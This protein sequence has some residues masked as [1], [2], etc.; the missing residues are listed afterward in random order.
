MA[1]SPRMLCSSTVHH[2]PTPY[3]VIG[4]PSRRQLLVTDVVWQ[5]SLPVGEEMEMWS[6][7]LP[8]L[9]STLD[10]PQD[11]CRNI[12][13][14]YDVNN[15][16]LTTNITSLESFSH[17][18]ANPYNMPP[19]FVSTRRCYMMSFIVIT[20]YSIAPVVFDT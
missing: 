12:L 6:N 15:Y 3:S 13:A 5:V 2:W 9:L 11:I 8:Y 1:Q 18:L 7:I 10:N 14:L 20:S 4:I 16:E 19:E 17:P